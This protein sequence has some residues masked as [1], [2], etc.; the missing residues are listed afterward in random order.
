MSMEALQ[1]REDLMKSIEKILKKFNQLLNKLLQDLRSINEELVEYINTP[2]WYLPT[3]SYDDDDEEECSIPLKDIIISG[4]PLVLGNQ[5][6][7]NHHLEEPLT[8][9]LDNGADYDPEEEIRRVERL[10]YDN[11]SPRPLEELNVENSIESFPPS[12]IP[13]ED[14]DPFM[15]EINLF[16]ASDESIPPGIDSD[17]SNS[18]GD[19]LFLERLLYDDPT[20]LPDIPSP[21]HVTFLFEEQH[22]LDFTCVV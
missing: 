19:N 7:L 10:L 1:A 2:N 14:S 11:S 17:Y 9:T 3:S 12:H 16:L 15:E 4:L 18:K 21:T 6:R 5:T 22:D 8:F 13:V 20:P